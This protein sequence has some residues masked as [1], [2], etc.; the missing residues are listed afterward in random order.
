[1]IVG[2][3]GVSCG[4]AL[5]KLST[6]G[7]SAISCI[8]AVISDIAALAGHPEIT[9]G[10]VTF[11]F[12]AIMIVAEIIML[13]RK[14]HPIQLL[15]F[16]ILFLFSW[17]IDAWMGLFS[18][19]PLPNYP[20]HLAML[21]ASMLV[22]GLG[23]FVEL[24]GNVLMLPGE[25]VVYTISY[26]SKVPFHRCKV[27]FDTSMICSAA[28]ISLLAMGGLYDV[29]EGSIISALLVGNIVKMWSTLFNGLDAVVPPAP[30]N[31]IAPVVPALNYGTQNS[32][33]K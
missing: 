7:T 15:Q 1:M 18:A 19:I 31:Y 8:P 6:T 14:F 16:P 13:R 12:N 3:G 25:A 28:V 10:V 21:A 23:V 11:A 20:A 5:A 33:K 2:I 30:K 22:L 26:V 32:G 4:I 27:F 24:K 9:L 29:R 17:A